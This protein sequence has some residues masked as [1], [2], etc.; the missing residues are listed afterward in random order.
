V[1]PGELSS[2]HEDVGWWDI[3]LSERFELGEGDWTL[4]LE[5]VPSFDSESKGEPV[6]MKVAAEPFVLRVRAAK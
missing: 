4:R 1:R 6:G 3:D 5:Y 2:S